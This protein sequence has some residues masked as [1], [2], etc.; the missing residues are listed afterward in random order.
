MVGAAAVVFL[1]FSAFIVYSTWAAF[2]G[3]HYWLRA[4]AARI[5]SRRFIRRKF[6]AIR[7]TRFLRHAGVVAGLHS[8]FAGVFDFVGA[9]RISF[10]LLLLSRRVLQGVLG[11]P[12][13]LR[14]RRA[15]QNISRRTIFSA[16]HPKRSP[17]FSLPRA[18]DLFCCS[19]TTR[20]RRCGSRTRSARNISA[21]AS[22]R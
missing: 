1:G 12:D 10:H 9:G 18:S 7:R 13:Q 6:G 20:G 21:S 16:H 5:I 8:V 4:P 14:R 3:N 11:R 15:A 2:Q 17:L 22:A 19:A